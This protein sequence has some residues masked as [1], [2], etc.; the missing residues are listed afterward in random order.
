MLP[1]EDALLLEDKFEIDIVKPN[2]DIQPGPFNFN[3]QLLTTNAG[4]IV[5]LITAKSKFCIK[6]AK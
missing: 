6:N 3:L 1:K 4:L 2:C 5:F